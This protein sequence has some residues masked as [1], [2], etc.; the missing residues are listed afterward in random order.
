MKCCCQDILKISRLQSDEE[1]CRLLSAYALLAFIGKIWTESQTQITTSLLSTALVYFSVG[2]LLGALTSGF[3]YL[4]QLCYSNESSV[5]KGKML[6]IF[7]VI[8]GL[9]T[10][11]FF[12]LGAWSVYCSFTIHF[13]P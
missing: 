12:G 10:Y 7:T 9:S 11:L 13:A 2:V 4:S 6:H 3:T 1:D 5:S 8:T